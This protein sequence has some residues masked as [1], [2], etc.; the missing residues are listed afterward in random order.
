MGTI[1]LIANQPPEIVMLP[2]VTICGNDGTLIV[3]EALVD[4]GASNY[5][6]GASFSITA[7]SLTSPMTLDATNGNLT[8][9][10]PIG[11]YSDNPLKMT[12]TTVAG[13]D[14]STN[15]TIQYDET[16]CP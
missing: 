3:D 5:L 2:T 13:T 9:T 10:P 16:V 11:T 12:A 6:T 1:T 14:E 4:S 8:G 15:F 7:G